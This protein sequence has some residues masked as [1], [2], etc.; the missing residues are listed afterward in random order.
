MDALDKRLPF[1]T[2]ACFHFDGGRLESRLE[3]SESVQKLRELL[4]V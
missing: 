4:D 2:Q 1:Y 3:I